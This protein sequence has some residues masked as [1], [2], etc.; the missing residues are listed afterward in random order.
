MNE[1]PYIIT[2]NSIEDFSREVLERSQHVPVLVDFWAAWCQPCQM[3]LPI[4]DKLAQDYAGQFILAKV[5]A[6]EQQ[7]IAAQ[8]G[9][10]SLPT[11]KLFVGGQPVE[12]IVGAQP[13]PAIKDILDRYISSPNDEIRM[14]A[15]AARYQGDFDRAIAI[16]QEL[17]HAEPDNYNNHLQLIETLIDAARYQDAEDVLQTL[18]A[19]IR[20]DEG[21]QQVEARLNFA[22]RMQDAPSREELQRRIEADPADLQ[23]RH[24][25]SAYQIDAGEY[26][27][28]MENLLEIMRRDRSF[29]DDAGRQGL[30]SLFAMLGSH[31]LVSHY[32][33][34]MSSL[35][36]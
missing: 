24:Q 3:L 22:L 17:L 16:L 35:L 21:A 2:I 14:Q 11:L 10:R 1:N 23:A 6:D 25:L 15:D 8:F 29:E 9:V 34:K 7:Q 26:E 30:L 13:E 32:R 36:F 4:L 19:N 12:E 5:N 28:A 20:A 33:R 31:P 27:A 18:P